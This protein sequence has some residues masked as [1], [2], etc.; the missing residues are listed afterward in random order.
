MSRDV[1]WPVYEDRL[2]CWLAP[3]VMGPI[4]SRVVRRSN[5]LF[6]DTGTHY[7]DEFHYIEGYESRG[8]LSAL[9]MAFGLK[10]VD[11][12]LR[13]GPGRSL[14]RALSPSP[15]QGPSENTMDNGFFRTKF[16]AEIQSVRATNW[17]SSS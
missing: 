3:F 13:Y 9:L 15:G 16:A 14:V 11:T 17:T 10:F 7:G 2:S 1:T 12:L 4:N 5:A 8:R 6:R